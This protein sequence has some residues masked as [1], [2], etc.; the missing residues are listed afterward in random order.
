MQT[1]LMLVGGAQEMIHDVMSHLLALVHGMFAAG[2]EVGAE[3]DAGIHVLDRGLGEALIRTKY[4][5]GC[6]AGGDTESDV[7]GPEELDEHGGRGLAVSGMLRD[8][9]RVNSD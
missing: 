9:I 6:R 2:A 8:V 4:P 3:P 5:A 1:A 7:V